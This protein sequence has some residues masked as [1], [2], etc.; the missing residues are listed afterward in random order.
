MA[1]SLREE[2]LSTRGVRAGLPLG[3]HWRGIDV[4]IHLGYRK[5]KR[6]GRWLVRYYIPHR[7]TYQQFVLGVADD[8]MSQGTLTFD[9]AVKLARQK[10][11]EIRA[12]ETAVAIPDKKPTVRASIERYVEMRDARDRAREGRAKRSDASYRLD[13]HVLSNRKFADTRLEFLSEETVGAW[14]S[15]L[16][17]TMSPTTRQRLFTDLKAAL[18]SAYRDHRRQL[19][20]DFP[21]VVR[22]SLRVEEAAHAVVGAREN[23]ILS[24]DC[25]R[26][27]IATATAI[28]EDDDFARLVLVLAATGARFSQVR[29]MTVGDVQCDRS[30]L[31]VPASHKGK[32]RAKNSITVQVGQDVLQALKPVL[33]GRDPAEPLLCRWRRV[34]TGP[35]TWERDRRGPWTSASEMGR[36]WAALCKAVGLK[37]VIP[38]ALRHSSIVRAIRA[39]LPIRLVAAMHD[40]SVVMIERHYSRWIVDGLEELAARAVIPLIADVE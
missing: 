23:Q 8:V 37:N 24:D 29:R 32:A 7:R 28:D 9:A 40:T 3:L 14:R 36:L 13:R 6:G 12:P 1:G 17:P 2:R 10:V 22:H 27:I 18:N 30:R 33:E 11:A 16:S 35:A 39:G 15:R 38:Y 25:V 5:G 4:D 31:H 26:K 34:Q 21:E 19:P 20:A